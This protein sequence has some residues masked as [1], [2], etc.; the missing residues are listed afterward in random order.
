MHRKSVSD[1]F[2]E[3]EMRIT[4]Q[5]QR[6]FPHDATDS[7]FA[8]ELS[9]AEQT[10]VPGSELLVREWDSGVDALLKQ[11]PVTL[12]RQVLALQA[13]PDHDIRPAVTPDVSPETALL[14]QLT[15]PSVVL[16]VRVFGPHQDM[17]PL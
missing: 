2:T 8:E 4:D 13:H 11:F 10:A 9:V 7:Q 17:E 12:L 15:V 16:S 14:H 5:F 6:S 3:K 1:L